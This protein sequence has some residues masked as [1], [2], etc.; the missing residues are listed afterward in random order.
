MHAVNVGISGYNH[1]IISQTI[2]AI[3]NIQ[4]SLKQVEFL[5]FINHFLRQSE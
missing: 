1:L 4:G 2:E 5:V 3:F